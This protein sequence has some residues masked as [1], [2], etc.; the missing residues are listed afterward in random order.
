[1]VSASDASAIIPNNSE[2]RIAVT[3]PQKR[4][5]RRESRPLFLFT[6][7][8]PP[9]N[10]E[11][12]IEKNARGF[13]ITC[14]LSSASASAEKIRSSEKRRAAEMIAPKLTLLIIPFAEALFL[15]FFFFIGIPLCSL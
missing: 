11:V 1:M 3:I 7:K 15:I 13:K 2:S 12:Y 9:K 6:D 14:G 4:P 10:A 8:N 5:Q